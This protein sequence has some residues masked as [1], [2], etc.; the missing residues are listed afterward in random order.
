MS[1]SEASFEALRDYLR[2]CQAAIYGKRDE[3][4][5]HT[6][7]LLGHS[8]LAA[9]SINPISDEIVTDAVFESLTQAS[10]DLSLASAE[11]LASI[12]KDL[13]KLPGYTYRRLQKAARFG[14]KKIP[15]WVLRTDGLTIEMWEG[16]PEQDRQRLWKDEQIPLR[17]RGMT[18]MVKASRLSSEGVR[19]II[20]PFNP[21][22]G[23]LSIDEQA[24]RRHR[25]RRRWRR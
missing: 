5:R 20:D 14:L 12:Q 22:L 6:T 11:Q 1:L 13:K 23:I 10:S 9:R 18:I 3:A 7:A 21:Q 8:G 17:S 19:Q 2:S 16:I 25:K 24:K 15:A 4:L